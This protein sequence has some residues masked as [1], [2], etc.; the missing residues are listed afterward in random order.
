[1]TTTIIWIFV[2]REYMLY[3]MWT[4]CFAYGCVSSLSQFLSSCS[5]FQGVCDHDRACGRSFSCDRHF[6][7]CFPLRG[8][9][10]YCRRDAQCVRG[11]SC[12]FGKCHRRI[13]EGQEGRLSDKGIGL[14]WTFVVDTVQF[15]EVN[16]PHFLLYWVLALRE[17]P[18]YI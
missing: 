2:S 10:Q 13:S 16:V 18:V 7:L 3:Q 17:G 11:L 6:G 12:M 14:T 8:E 9:G 4:Q 5:V 1:M 15:I